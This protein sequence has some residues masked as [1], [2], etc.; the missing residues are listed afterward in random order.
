MA[1]LQVI[2]S[3]ELRKPHASPALSSEGVS[4]RSKGKKHPS[5]R[6]MAQ[7]APLLAHF[8]C[9]PWADIPAFGQRRISGARRVGDPFEVRLRCRCHCYQP[10]RDSAVERLSAD[11]EGR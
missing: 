11:L 3:F 5:L 10:M 6:H 2:F 7:N 4:P 1:S 8:W 9:Q